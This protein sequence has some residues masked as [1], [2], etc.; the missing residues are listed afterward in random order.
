MSTDHAGIE[1]RAGRV[2]VEVVFDSSREAVWE[3]FASRVA[4]WWPREF[5]VAGAESVMRLEMVAGGRLF[6]ESG[7]SSVLWATV[8][9]VD[10]G[11]GVNLVG[12]LVPP[13][14]GPASSY[15]QLVF[16]DTDDGGCML[17]L[18]DTVIGCI[19][20]SKLGDAGEGWRM[21]FEGGL[22]AFVDGDS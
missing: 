19:D 11:R 21:I 12:H 6:E 17:R 18:T 22:K 3:A 13:F 8:L 20:Q 15:P 1:V 16:A 9:Q 5:L 7:E 10:A 14:G 2:E 4:D